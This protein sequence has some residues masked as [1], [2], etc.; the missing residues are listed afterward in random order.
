MIRYIKYIFVLQYFH[1]GIN[2]LILPS[3]KEL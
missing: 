2:A 3:K 1:F